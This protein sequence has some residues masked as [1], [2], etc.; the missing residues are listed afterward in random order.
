MSATQLTCSRLMLSLLGVGGAPGAS[1]I[2]NTPP[3]PLAADARAADGDDNEPLL[4]PADTG[5]GIGAGAAGAV[6]TFDPIAGPLASAGMGFSSQASASNLSLADDV[7][8]ACAVGL[9]NA[10][11]AAAAAAAAAGAGTAAGA[12]ADAGVGIVGAETWKGL[13]SPGRASVGL[14]MGSPNS[15][16]RRTETTTARYLLT[17]R[18]NALRLF[19]PQR[20]RVTRLQD[21]TPAGACSGAVHD[22]HPRYLT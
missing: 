12:A 10:S 20:R 16:A 18:R 9:E 3:T 19:S 14:F 22:M 15:V 6:A 8:A 17:P 11:A 4:L 1:I 21:S 2:E 5:A 13:Q 7:L